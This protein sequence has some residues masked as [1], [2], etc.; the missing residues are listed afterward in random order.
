MQILSVTLK[1]FKSHSDRCFTFQ[2]GT[3][4]I[5]GENGAGKTSIL[6]AI[7][8]TL[9]DYIG[10]YTKDDLIRNGASSAQVR[11]AFVSPR[12]GRTYEIQRCTTKSYTIYDPQLNE[13]LP[14]SRIK[15]EVLPWLRQHLGVA[16][17]TDL[18]QLFCSTIG[19]PQGT[20]TTDFLL[21]RERR[22]PIFDKIL[23]VEEYQ[24]TW[25][26]LAD[27]EK[28]ARHQVEALER[29]VAYLEENLE[30]LDGLQVKRQQQQQEIHTVQ[31]ELQQAQAQV[32]ELQQHVEQLQALEARS[33]HLTL[34]LAQVTTQIQ[35]QTGNL[36][37][38]Q[39]DLQQAEAAAAICTANQE[40]YQVFQQAE[41]TLRQLEQLQ[42]TE[43]TLQHRKRQQEQQLSDRQAELTKLTLQLNRL[44]EARQAI[45]QLE[46]LAQRQQELER[47]QQTISQQIQTCHSMRQA[48]HEQEKRLK[49][50]QIRQTH[51][52][53]EI[54]EIQALAPVVQEIPALEQQQ[55]RLQQQISRVAAAIQFE[56]ELRQIFQA[57]QSSNDSFREQ[58]LKA[59]TALTDLQQAMPLWSG[60]LEAVLQTLET[61]LAMQQQF[62][63]AL[64]NIL[65]DL[66]EQTAPEKLAH[67][68]QTVQ[69]QLQAARQNQTRFANLERLLADY[70]HLETDVR[71]LQT[72]LMASQSQ[73]AE[74]SA[75]KEKYAHL[76]ATLTELENPIARIQLWREDLRQEATLL[77]SLEAV[78]QAINEIQQAIAHL[79]EQ[80]ATYAT[81]ADDI[82]KQQ[83]I[84]D[85][86]RQAYEVYTAHRELANTRKQRLHLVQTVTAELQALQQ[87]QTALTEERDRLCQTFDPEDYQ[88]AQTAYQTAR[89]R[90]N[91]LSGRL[92]ELLKAM[93]NLDERLNQLEI[94]RTQYVETQT[95]LEQKKR[96]ERF[97]KFARKAYKEAGPRITERYIQS[98]SRE[99]DKLFRDL[100]HR[101]NVSLRWTRDYEIVVQEGAHSRRF[102]NLSGGEQMCAALAVR[103][104]LLKVLADLDIAFFDEPTT[105]MD[106]LRREQLADAIANIKTFQQLF[107][108]SHDDTFEKVTENI[109]V[110]ER[111][112]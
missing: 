22:K 10:D 37:R 80:L 79:D 4:A 32:A 3:N 23:K 103:L 55:Q 50:L 86:H 58:V 45:A 11:V 63:T 104:A 84:R 100:L 16:P 53:Q 71:E 33:Q 95:Q 106:R 111:E 67:Q 99:A 39:Q 52:N 46:P 101:P 66:A 38:L 102:V 108:I 21:P 19:V 73:I 64:G 17:G 30:E 14:Y 98:I 94:L 110:V 26:K 91:L 70:A 82:L 56:T 27:L 12:D 74:E 34:Q 61:G 5:C 59:T 88:V 92:P 25:K 57:S 93:E 36:E 65:D 44:T 7:A 105:N 60:T 1:N 89:D 85:Q 107:V 48:M 72:H 62:V 96:I 2:P 9:F 35:T 109:I 78:N 6:E 81:L 87:T 51:L 18:G 24:Q 13:R 77:A 90:Q 49:Q 75:L 20:F 76:A 43:Q 69:T 15:E 41:S 28:Y 83:A 40:A 97:I 8:W 68:L 29:E 42:R 47:T 54:A 31:A 112:A